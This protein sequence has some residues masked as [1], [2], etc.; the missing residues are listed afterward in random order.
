MQIIDAGEDRLPGILAIYNQVIA[1]STAVYTEIPATLADRA[2]W[3]GARLAG[4]FPVLAAVNGDEVLGFASFGEWR[5]AWPGYRLTVEHSVHVR[6]GLRGAGVGRAL[7]EAL[8]ARARLGGWHVM[9]GSVDADN[10][11][12]I[13]FHERLGFSSAAHFRQ[14]GVKFDR[15]LDMVFMQL[16]LDDA[17]I[18]PR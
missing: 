9:L 16:I 2:A 3:R 17:A 10:A 6:D 5:G 14:V 8:I 18:P 7:M 1:S 12:S 11:A 4:G 13:A 15:W